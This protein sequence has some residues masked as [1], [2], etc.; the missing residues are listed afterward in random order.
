LNE[1]YCG[2]NPDGDEEV[3]ALKATKKRLEEE[4]SKESSH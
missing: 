2:I 1:W 4:I 3:R